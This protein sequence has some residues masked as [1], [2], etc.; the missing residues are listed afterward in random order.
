MFFCGSQNILENADV[1]QNN[2]SKQN[3]RAKELIY[4]YTLSGSS[5]HLVQFGLQAGEG[6]GEAQRQLPVLNA[7]FLQEVSQAFSNVVKQLAS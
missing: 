4:I 7:K 6:E 3:K 5:A 2:A 1:Q